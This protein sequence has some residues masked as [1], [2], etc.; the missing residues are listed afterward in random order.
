M[1]LESDAA[2]RAKMIKKSPRYNAENNNVG[3][4]PAMGNV[5]GR[6]SPTGKQAALT[7]AKKQK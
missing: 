7:T 3:V 1:Q 2:K 6:A 4:D 5:F